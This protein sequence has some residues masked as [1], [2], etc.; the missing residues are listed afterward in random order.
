MREINPEQ[1]TLKCKMIQIYQTHNRT[2][3]DPQHVNINT[4]ESNNKATSSTEPHQ[5]LGAPR[6]TL[7]NLSLRLDSGELQTRLNE[8]KEKGLQQERLA[9][10]GRRVQ[11]SE[12]V[13][14][15]DY[16]QRWGEDNLTS[17]HA[18]KQ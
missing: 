4:S 11:R 1:G 17:T 6:R 12:Q 14:S 9:V 18:E 5:G 2:R 10:S 8:R 15:N 7:A 13:I 16:E 3:A